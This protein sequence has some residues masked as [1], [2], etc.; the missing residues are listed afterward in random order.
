[1][2]PT[3]D[4]VSTVS[5]ILQKAV[6]LAAERTVGTSKK[7]GYERLLPYVVKALPFLVGYAQKGKTVSYEQVSH[8]TGAGSARNGNRSFG[9]IGEVR[10]LLNKELTFSRDSK[11]IPDLTSI[12]RHSTGETSGEG[13]FHESPEMRKKSRKDQMTELQE[14]RYDVFHYP[15]WEEVL[16][17]LGLQP[18]MNLEPI[19]VRENRFH[20]FGGEGKLH[21]SLKTFVS[22]HPELLHS[23]LGKDLTSE[24][25]YSFLSNDRLDVI[26]KAEDEWIGIEVKTSECNEDE[27]IRGLFQVV[28]YKALL[29]ATLLMKSETKGFRC[30]LVIGGHASTEIAQMAKRLKVEYIS[31]VESIMD[32]SK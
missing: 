23:T 16:S 14:R 12:V 32:Q 28:K 30:M 11:R 7:I 13:V 6:Q 20:P 3:S 17:V 10:H 1:M 22:Q 25:E 18:M 9:A 19:S 4:S 31:E 2:Q 21:L 8:A 24:V 15:R 5:P 29:R 26:L 27:L